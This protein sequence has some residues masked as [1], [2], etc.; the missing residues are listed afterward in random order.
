MSWI[1][2]EA[3]ELLDEE[4][5]F[6]EVVL[7]SSAVISRLN[8][9][10]VDIAFNLKKNGVLSLTAPPEPPR[11]EK[12]IRPSGG[13]SSSVLSTYMCKGLLASEKTNPD[14]ILRNEIKAELLIFHQ[15]TERDKNELN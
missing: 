2:I 9:I 7:P 10:V 6:Q 12:T 5:G 1:E 11:Q 8:D 14:V 13:P 4:G 3:V 15:E